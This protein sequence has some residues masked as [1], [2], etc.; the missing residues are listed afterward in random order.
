ME[1]TLTAR[2]KEA[3]RA[4]GAD[5]VG[6]APIGRFDGIAKMHH[7]SSIFPETR[8]VVVVGKR[9]VRGCLRGVEEGTQFSL[10]NTYAMNWLPHRFLARRSPAH[11]NGR[12]TP[13]RPCRRRRPRTRRGPRRRAWRWPR[14]GAG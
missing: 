2:F 11:R 14:A 9:I 6:I 7:P 5:L 4:A 3:T 1:G 13:L 8:S 12:A 10:Y